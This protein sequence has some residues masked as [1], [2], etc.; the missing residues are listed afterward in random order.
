MSWGHTSD[1]EK[2]P[3]TRRYELAIQECLNLMALKTNFTLKEVFTE[4]VRARTARISL[5]RLQLDIQ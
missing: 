5:N 3:F 4:V 2:L 1:D